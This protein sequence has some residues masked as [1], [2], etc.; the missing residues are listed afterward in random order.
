MSIGHRQIE[1]AAVGILSDATLAAPSPGKTI[2][3][4]WLQAFG[5]WTK[6]IVGLV[7]PLLLGA[8]LLEVFVTPKLVPLIFGGR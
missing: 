7:L 1:G 6:V 2:G 5:D 4:A 3:E 8:A